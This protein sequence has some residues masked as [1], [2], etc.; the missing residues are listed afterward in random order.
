MNSRIGYRSLQDGAQ[1]SIDKNLPGYRQHSLSLHRYK[2]YENRA[3]E[4][5]SLQIF[6]DDGR[7]VGS[8]WKSYIFE[9]DFRP[10]AFVAERRWCLRL[11]I[12]I[13]VIETRRVSM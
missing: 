4:E 10:D 9:L 5:W 13:Q 8:P 7:M 11:S 6:V 1:G 3:R 2:R 12:A